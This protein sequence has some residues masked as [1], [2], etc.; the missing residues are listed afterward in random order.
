M[1]LDPALSDAIAEAARTSGQ[2][3]AVARRLLAWLARLSDGEL[4]RGANAEFY[5]STREVILLKEAED[6]D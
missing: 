3:Q 4:S 5:E 6:E 2:P 1:A